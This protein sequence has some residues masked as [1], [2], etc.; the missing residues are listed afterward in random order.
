MELLVNVNNQ[1][2]RLATNLKSLVAGSQQF[3]KFTFNLSDEWDD[4]LPFA[5]FIQDNSTY[6]SYLDTN[7]SVYLPPEIHAGRCQVTLYGTN[8][9]V[10][11]TTNR[12]ELNIAENNIVVDANSIDITPTLY[13]QLVD[14]FNKL[15]KWQQI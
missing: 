5:Q 15:S 9:R 13:E 12:L 3:I 2:L 10:V 1:K 6:N 8:G 14:K 11:S 4:L 7:N